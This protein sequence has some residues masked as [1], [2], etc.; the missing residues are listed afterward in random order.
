MMSLPD[1]ATVLGLLISKAGIYV[2]IQVL[3]LLKL[4]SI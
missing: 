3:S 4:E 1:Y 2:F